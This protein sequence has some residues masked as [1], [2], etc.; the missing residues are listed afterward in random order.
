MQRNPLLPLALVALVTLAGCSAPS[1][2]ATSSTSTGP[3]RTAH[4]GDEVGYFTIE[5]I[6]AETVDGTYR[7]PYPVATSG[8][9]P[10]TLRVGDEVGAACEGK[11]W[12]LSSIDAAGQSVTFTERLH[13]ESPGGCPIC[14]SGD[15]M[16]DTPA[17]PMNV[18]DVRIGT[19]V[20]S[21][22]DGERVAAPVEKV[23]RT[24]SPAHAV[25]ELVLEDGRTLSVSP[26]HP[27]ADGRP[28]GS[29]VAG[30]PVDGVRVLSTK[31]VKYEQPYTY[32]ILVSDGYWANGIP[33]ASTLGD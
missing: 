17:G 6:N 2:R 12:V 19:V 27:L 24:P 25:V 22:K 8:G 14:L 29:L 5:R 3:T 15:T 11:T 21:L 16:I 23:S 7:Y 10:R 1:E 26:G 28:V 9:S 20:W 30:D 18:K 32:D 31:L 13:G 33:M 4:V